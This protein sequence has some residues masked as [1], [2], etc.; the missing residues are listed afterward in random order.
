MICFMLCVGSYLVLG[1]PVIHSRVKPHVGYEFGC[2]QVWDVCK[3]ESDR[4]RYCVVVVEE[5]KELEG[6]MV[7]LIIPDPS[8]TIKML[9][10][11][12]GRVVTEVKFNQDLDCLTSDV[13]SPSFPER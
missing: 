1:L 13:R 2:R 3:R 10:A 6:D 11:G 9:K 12:P 5:R 7:G 8:L 4:G